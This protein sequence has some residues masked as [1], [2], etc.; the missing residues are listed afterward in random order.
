MKDILAGL[1]IISKY[2]PQSYFSAEHDQIWCGDATEISEE[3]L[4]K[5]EKLGW[6]K[7]EDSMSHYT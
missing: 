6:F 1:I 2:D 7:S 3:D 5:L 4:E